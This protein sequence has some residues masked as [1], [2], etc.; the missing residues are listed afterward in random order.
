V[1]KK[2]KE[3]NYH[4]QACLSTSLFV[5]LLQVRLD[6][7]SNSLETADTTLLVAK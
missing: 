4:L 3:V 7:N 1:A 6:H 5:K 2:T